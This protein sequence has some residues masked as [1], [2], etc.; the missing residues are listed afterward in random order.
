MSWPESSVAQFPRSNASAAGRSAGSSEV[1]TGAVTVAV[2]VG[3]A[4]A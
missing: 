4:G 1:S 3:S 2:T